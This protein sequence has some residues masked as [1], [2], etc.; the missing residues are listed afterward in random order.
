MSDSRDAPFGLLVVD[1]PTE[2]TSHDVVKKVRHLTQ[3]RKVG[4]TGTLDPLATG[5][6]VLC[7]G[8]ATRLADA[9][10]ANEKRYRG[11]VRFGTATTTYDREGEPTASGEIDFER[12]DLEQALE[13]FSGEIRQRPP[14]WSALKLSGERAFERARRGEEVVLEPRPVTIHSLTLTKWSPPDATIDVHCSSGT[15]IRSLAHDLGESIGCPAHLAGLRRTSCGAFDLDDAASLE[16]LVANAER[17]AWRSRLRPVSDGLPATWPSITVDSDGARLLSHGH[18]V[19]IPD[20]VDLDDSATCQL[21]GPDGR[22]LAL[23][24]ARAERGE[25]RPIKVFVKPGEC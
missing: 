6:L 8:R 15:Y 13:P 19:T 1:K 22:F 17:D 11:I 14:A 4:H 23:A 18:D 5:V 25:L 3:T 10:Q 21:Y 7:I 9:L 2:W 16:G 24:S 12:R 20:D